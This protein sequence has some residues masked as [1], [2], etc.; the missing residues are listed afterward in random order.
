M[1]S[2]QKQNL[3]GKVCPQAASLWRFQ[4]GPNFLRLQ[5]LWVESA[6]SAGARFERTSSQ[7]R[8]SFFPGLQECGSARKFIKISCQVPFGSAEPFQESLDVLHWRA[9]S[10][11]SLSSSA[12]T[13]M[14][15]PP[16]RHTHT[17]TLRPPAR[18]VYGIW[19]RPHEKQT[20][21]DQTLVFWLKTPK[22]KKKKKISHSI[23]TCSP[24]VLWNKD[25]KD[26]LWSYTKFCC[27]KQS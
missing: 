11:F 8:N 23:P 10:S 3:D 9:A 21:V 2:H 15:K 17:H 19:Q 1:R 12:H 4:A 16:T 18:S 22:K 7:V 24:V 25:F 27:S 6:R 5:G 20:L 14:P 13:Q 26:L